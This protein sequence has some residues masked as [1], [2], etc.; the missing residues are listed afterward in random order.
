MRNNGERV[1]PV[2]RITAVWLGNEYTAKLLANDEDGQKQFASGHPRLFGGYDDEGLRRTFN[3]IAVYDASSQKEFI[4]RVSQPLFDLSTSYGIPA[5]A[6]GV[7]KKPDLRPHTTLEMGRI[8]PD[9]P[10]DQV[11]QIMA[12]MDSS[13]SHIRPITEI[14]NGLQFRHNR[15][16]MAPNA[17]TCESTP[18]LGQGVA[19]RVRRLVL[20]AMA[21][22]LRGVIHPEADN[23]KFTE[24]YRYDNLFHCS[25]WRAVPPDE[26]QEIIPAEAWVEFAQEADATIGK[27]LRERPMLLRVGSVYAGDAYKFINADAP[28]LINH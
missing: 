19:I 4:R 20:K 23:K 27:S 8:S 18:D 22:S 26:F 16:V 7:G 15:L 6:S 5:L 21:D 28:H 2:D 10:E 1:Y 24:P 13:Y 14:L 12:W 3:L 17:Y 11:K 25:A 9:L